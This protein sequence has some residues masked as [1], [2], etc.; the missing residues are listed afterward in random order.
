VASL[1]RLGG[2]AE[3]IVERT[4]ASGRAATARCMPRLLR[5]ALVDGA[6]PIPRLALSDVP[7][8]D[9]PADRDGQVG[10]GGVTA[11]VAHRNGAWT[12]AL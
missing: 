10:R 1:P 2:L 3:G 4:G 12:Q 11:R 7:S 9:A 5:H 6:T 8:A